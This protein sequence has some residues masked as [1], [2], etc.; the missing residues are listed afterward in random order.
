MG[1]TVRQKIKG[2]G[3]PWH[4]FVHANGRIRS[5]KIGN[6]RLAERRA[7]QLREELVVNK[8]NLRPTKEVPRFSDYAKHYMEA[9]AKEN[10]KRNTWR[11][12]ETILEKHLLPVWNAK[13][14][15]EIKRAD[16]KKLL[17]R[18]QKDGLSAGTVRNIRTLIS[19]IFTLAVEEE[20][21]Q[22]HPASKLGRRNREERQSPRKHIETL[23]KEQVSKVLAVAQQDFPDSYAFL[24]C[25]FR[26]GMRLGE[27]VGL[28]WEDVD[29]EGNFLEVTRSF[30]HG[31]FSTPK[32][33]KSRRVDMSNQLRQTLL[34]HRLQLLQRFRGKLPAVEGNAG[35]IHLV[36]P[37]SGGIPMDAHNFRRRTFRKILE[38]ADVPEVRIHD[39]RHTFASLLLAAGEPLHY[40]KDQ[41][42][43]AS[44]QTTVDVY[45]HIV[46]GSNRN[47]VNRLDD[48]GDFGLR[49]VKGVG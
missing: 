35:E 10:L 16:V 14:L 25:A 9:Y 24:L 47:A 40:V 30:S 46:P 33:H 19:G 17:Q 48:K 6:K 31:Y 20:V 2:K 3:M 7:A 44:I 21:L 45:G 36:F 49:V 41:L 23:S 18:K 29:F 28:A 27:L 11:G 8:F 4:V 32:N 34:A 43:H 37:S 38:K 12:Y 26:T 39:M 5:E 15:D 13:R 22:S 42:G 1:V